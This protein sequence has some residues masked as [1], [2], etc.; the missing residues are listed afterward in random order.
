MSGNGTVALSAP[1]LLQAS[2]RQA[3]PLLAA[4]PSLRRGLPQGV[5]AASTPSCSRSVKNLAADL[6][7]IERRI[8]G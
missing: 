6:R 2:R 7:R 4:G 3:A 1:G 5:C 8:A